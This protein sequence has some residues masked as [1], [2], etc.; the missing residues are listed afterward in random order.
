MK[1]TAILVFAIFLV[2]DT[3]EARGLARMSQQ[4]AEVDRS[5]V[6]KIFQQ[7]QVALQ[8]DELDSAEAD[9]RKVLR[10]DP[11]AAAAYVNL[12]VIEM[13]RKNWD[14]ALA[15]LRHAEKLAPTMAGIRLN[16][17]LAEYK[18]GNYPDAIGPLSAA[19][20]DQ[21]HAV[22]PRYLLG[23]CYSFVGEH[24]DAAKTLEPLWPQMS[25]QF[26][27]LYVLG[28]S[29]FYSGD[30]ELDQKASQRLVE[31]GA[32]TP[33]FHL[34]MGKAMLNRSDDQRALEEFKKVEAADPNFSF[35]HFNLG[36]AYEHL[37]D[38]E[39]EDEALA[40]YREAL[41][42]DPRLPLSRLE[43]ARIMHRHRE[44]AK[45]L[46][47]LDVAVKYAPKN[48]N[49]HLLRGQVLLRLGRKE[50][51]QVELAKS[52]ELFASGLVEERAKMDEHLVPN[53]EL[54]RDK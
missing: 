38:H 3:M 42:R 19:M 12:G 9:F 10:A 46:Q 25:D 1:R 37:Q 11:Q 40:E 23:L 30:K 18:R 13:R 34:L 14:K 15:E 35:L 39:K 33:Q 52:K 20:R 22:Q 6:G 5:D 41:K 29:A 2:V 24:A 16:I 28:I 21:P 49:V 27:Y 36:M 45:A 54:T 53:P 51:G 43:V 4:A 50:E 7:G 32:D 8:A 47:E 44:E 48:R 17:G 31:V 26:V